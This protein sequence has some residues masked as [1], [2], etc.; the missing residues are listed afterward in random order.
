M[1]KLKI[2]LIIL[3][4]ITIM[5]LIIGK[6]FYG[7]I[8]DSNVVADSELY[9]PSNATFKDVYDKVSP[10]LKNPKSFIWASE[11][12]K[13]TKIKGGRYL[14]KEGMTNNDIINILRSGNQTPLNISFNNQDSLEKLAGRIAFQI[15]PDSLTIL[16]AL[17]DSTFFKKNGFNNKTALAMYIPNSYELY[18]N[19]SAEQFRGRMLK[20]YNRFWTSKRIDLAKKQG[21]TPMEATTIAS[22]VQ[23][24][25]SEIS[26]RK[27]VAGLYL[28]R[29]KSKW[30]LESDPTVI[31][32]LKLKYGFDTVIK[33]VLFKDLQ[34]DS[35]YN[36]YK[37][38]GIPPGPIAMPDISSIEAV[39][40]PKKHNYYFMCASVDKIGTHEFAK[41]LAQH[42]RNA[43]KYQKWISK[44]GIYR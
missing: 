42:N 24:E 13:Y 28:N 44:L 37:Y 18:W 36:T 1:S 8:Y 10:L 43:R 21:L 12:K 25:T 23:K 6:I 20:E 15:E 4:L 39:L 11:K 30:P 40:N 33:R 7:K 5:I 9:I 32:S 41:T 22:I 29:Y 34:I 31:Y 38:L 2:T 35:P 14:I 27:T 16:K 19:T 17:T 26:E 3:S